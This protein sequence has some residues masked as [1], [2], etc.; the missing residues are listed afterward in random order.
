M[1]ATGRVLL[2]EDHPVV[3]AGCR[4]ILAER[5]GLEIIEA[6]SGSAA[7]R[8]NRDY[9]PDFII[10]DLNLPDLS[11]LD[12]LRRLL[13]ESPSTKIL[14]FSMYE[15]A[16]FVAGALEAG[17][18]G[19]ITKGDDPATLLDALDQIAAG[20]IFL[21]HSVARKL[22]LTKLQRPSLP[23]KG[24]SGREMDLLALLAAGKSLSEIA[25]ELAISYRTTAGI[26][27]NM[28][29]KLGLPTITA[30]VK[31]AVENA[32]LPTPNMPR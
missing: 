10:L 23:T 22:A 16:A 6:D 3:R 25:A 7:V 18:H 26:A 2:V 32:R 28:R 9:A 20:E 29:A 11:G 4:R 8:L 1:T 27:A 14:I 15:D 24:L 30:L 5:E 12:L 13:A 19:Y 21:G 31:F 17:A